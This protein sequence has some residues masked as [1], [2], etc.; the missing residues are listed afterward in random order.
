[1]RREATSPHFPLITGQQQLLLPRAPRS[2]RDSPAHHCLRLLLSSP[3]VMMTT[4]LPRMLTRT[5]WLHRHPPRYPPPPGDTSQQPANGL[6]ANIDNFVPVHVGHDKLLSQACIDNRRT[7]GIY[8]DVKVNARFPCHPTVDPLQFRYDAAARQ[9]FVAK[10]LGGDKGLSIIAP[11]IPRILAEHPTAATATARAHLSAAQLEWLAELSNQ[12]H[13]HGG[14]VYDKHGDMGKKEAACDKLWSH[15]QRLYSSSNSGEPVLWPTAQLTS[16]WDQILAPRTSILSCAGPAR[17][18][19]RARSASMKSHHI[20]Q[21]VLHGATPEATYIIA[22]ALISYDLMR[23]VSPEITATVSSILADA[24]SDVAESTDSSE[25]DGGWQQQRGRKRRAGRVARRTED[26]I[27][28]KLTALHGSPEMRSV[29]AQYRQHI[30]SPLLA[31]ATKLSVRPM[32]QPYI[33]V[34]IDNWQSLG[35]NIHDLE[36][37][38][39]YQQIV[40]SRP[41]FLH[42]TAFWSVTQRIGN[43]VVSLWIREEHKELL[44]DLNDHVRSIIPQSQPA[45]RVACTVVKKSK[46]GRIDRDSAI[47]IFLTDQ[48]KVSPP[49]AERRP[50]QSSLQSRASVAAPGS[51][52]ARVIAGVRRAAETSSLNHRPRKISRSTGPPS[53]PPAVSHSAPPPS[54][55]TAPRERKRAEQSIRPSVPATSDAAP[56]TS[57]PQGVTAVDIQSQRTRNT[58]ASESLDARLSAL[59]LRLMQRMEQR[60]DELVRT[61]IDRLESMFQRLANSLVDRVNDLLQGVV[62]PTPSTSHRA[63]EERKETS[64][65]TRNYA[66]S[67]AIAR[68]RPRG[69][70][71]VPADCPSSA[72]MTLSGSRPSA[73]AGPA[74]N[75]SAVHNG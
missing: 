24:E 37:D 3:W 11:A 15:L 64:E 63:V 1:V 26:A 29:A 71:A 9:R 36:H 13:H 57:S 35:C 27:R 48:T 52:A 22:C 75:G 55:V 44:A 59:E 42:P 47:K 73:T 19:L 21:L 53:T 17:P 4:T 6:N 68:G 70:G 51:Y 38:A 14:L 46:R 62:S 18:S 58:S 72:T 25:E 32:L 28:R 20:Y 2:A 45:L 67:P 10:F 74:H 16:G 65:A 69:P 56:P 33:S 30:A 8:V 31:L 54:S 60:I 40:G 39:V 50:P 41:E 61:Q 5:T 12:A 43:A 23:V 66:D 7:D 49:T 34:M